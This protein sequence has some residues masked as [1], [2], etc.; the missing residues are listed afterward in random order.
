MQFETPSS[1]NARSLVRLT[2]PHRSIDGR[3][4][5]DHWTAR[6]RE[7]I[8]AVRSFFERR[9]IYVGWY[10]RAPLRAVRP[11]STPAVGK[12]GERSYYVKVR[13]CE[14]PRRF[15]AQLSRASTS[16]S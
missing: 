10:A 9:A 16:A 4:E 5:R 14:R 15:R 1:P 3:D 13:P 8:S 11:H 6:V 12:L 2:V 7:H